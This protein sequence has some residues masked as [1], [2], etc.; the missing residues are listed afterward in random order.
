MAK[1]TRMCRGWLLAGL[2]AAASGASAVPITGE[3]TMGGDLL[4]VGGAGLGSA[5]GLDFIGDD[6]LVL[7]A[8]GDLATTVAPG[9]LGSITD[10]SFAPAFAGPVSDFWQVGGWHFELDSLSVD[11]QNSFFLFLSGT[12]IL[13]GNGYDPTPGDW[14]FSAQGVPGTNLFSFSA[15]DSQRP[16]AVPEPATLALLGLGLAGLGLV[17]KAQRADTGVPS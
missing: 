7:D 11:F 17:R 13:S 2:L 6:F 8:T 16:P 3:L 15:A 5:T 10:F 1:N 14:I 4:P 9:D 12:G